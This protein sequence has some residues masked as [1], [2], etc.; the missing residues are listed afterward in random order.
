MQDN[1]FDKISDELIENKNY[2]KELV[3]TEME[4]FNR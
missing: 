4:A 1:V 3:S 2:L